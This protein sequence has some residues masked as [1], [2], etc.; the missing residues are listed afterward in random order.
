MAVDW[1]GLFGNTAE[2]LK[3]YPVGVKFK[4]GAGFEWDPTKM[5]GYLT[6]T[7]KTDLAIKKATLAAHE[8]EQEELYGTKPKTTLK[9]DKR[10]PEDLA[11]GAGYKPPTVGT[12]V[13]AGK[14]R[15]KDWWGLKDV[16]EIGK[17]FEAPGKGR[18]QV[19]IKGYGVR[20]VEPYDKKLGT[21]KPS[22]KSTRYIPSK[23][24]TAFAA[25]M[26]ANPK[27]ALKLWGDQYENLINDPEVTS[28]DMK[29]LNGIIYRNYYEEE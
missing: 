21:T 22:G 15:T 16:E 13:T 10:L 14:P 26:A 11:V 17:V 20:Y 25:E 8:K 2:F 18:E 29:W 27:G 9:I 6:E 3:K 5:P 7:G 12:E 1:A 4:G 28:E 24:A 23:Q 19:H